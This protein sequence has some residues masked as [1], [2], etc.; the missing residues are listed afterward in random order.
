MM[1]L[2]NHVYPKIGLEKTTAKMVELLICMKMTLIH[3]RSETPWETSTNSLGNCQFGSIAG[4]SPNVC[5]H[6]KNSYHI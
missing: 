2:L 1:E 4:I 3:D 6:H 5:L